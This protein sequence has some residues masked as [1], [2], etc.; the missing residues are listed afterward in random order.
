V[1]AQSEQHAGQQV[2]DERLVLKQEHHE[3]EFHQLQEMVLKQGHRQI[4]VE[5]EYLVLR[6][7]VETLLDQ[8]HKREC[9]NEEA[10]SAETNKLKCAVAQQ[11]L[12]LL[13][14]AAEQQLVDDSLMGLHTDST[15]QMRRLESHEDRSNIENTFTLINSNSSYLLF[16][17]TIGWRFSNSRCGLVCCSALHLRAPRFPHV[18]CMWRPS[19]TQVRCLKAERPLQ[20]RK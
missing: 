15:K 6:D 2:Q 18:E 20:D 9:E 13:D 8:E 12:M 16:N 10:A 1:L 7:K 17:I 3:L 5:Q 4:W 14:L 11:L 19:C